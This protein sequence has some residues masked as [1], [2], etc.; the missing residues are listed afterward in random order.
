MVWR[1]AARF[2]GRVCLDEIRREVIELEEEIVASEVL[3]SSPLPLGEG[4]G[5]GLPG[6]G[7]AERP[8]L[9][10]EPGVARGPVPRSDP[11]PRSLAGETP[12]LPAEEVERLSGELAEARARALASHRRALLAE[13][14]GRV[15]PELVTGSTAEE[16]EASLEIARR[17]FETVR[18]ATMAEMASTPVPA[19]N[20]PRQGAVLEGMSSMEKIAYGLKR[21]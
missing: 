10:D 4:R 8:A 15:V 19:G 21:D 18:A 5:E 1:R 6:T 12:A 11:V 17:A 9:R 13:N 2:E 20:P 3:D 7:G 14:A 16:M